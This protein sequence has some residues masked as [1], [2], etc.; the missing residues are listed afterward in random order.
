ME[1]LNRVYVKEV[2]VKKVFAIDS[3]EGFWV[4]ISEA[5]GFCEISPLEVNKIFAIGSFDGF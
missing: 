4:G 5:L 3:C 1:K 2:E